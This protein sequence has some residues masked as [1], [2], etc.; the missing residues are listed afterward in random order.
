MDA[1]ESLS[2][3]FSQ[4]DIIHNIPLYVALSCVAG[5]TVWAGLVTANMSENSQLDFNSGKWQA[6]SLGLSLNSRNLKSD[7]FH[8]MII[9]FLMKSMKILR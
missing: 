7:Y 1:C 8:A 2:V 5:G 3:K 4:A 6:G 9:R